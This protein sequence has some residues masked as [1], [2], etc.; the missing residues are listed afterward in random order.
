VGVVVIPP[1]SSF[2]SHK[3][4]KRESGAGGCNWV[5]VSLGNINTEIRLSRL[6]V[7]RKAD[8]LAL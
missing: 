5:T 2:F 3:A 4:T 6:G 8:D 7:G 1:P